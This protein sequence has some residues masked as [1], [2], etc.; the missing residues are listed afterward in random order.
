MGSG[1][2]NLKEILV[3]DEA[4]A[5]IKKMSGNEFI[6]FEN[7]DEAI[8]LFSKKVLE[9]GHMLVEYINDEPAGYI[10]FYCNDHATKTGF[11]TA[12][13]VSGQGLVKGKIIM[14]LAKMAISY[15][16]KAGMTQL[17]VQ[18][19]KDNK[20]ARK[21]YEQLGLEYTGEENENGL[22]MVVSIEKLA[23]AM[24]IRIDD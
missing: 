6:T 14:N 11:V 9:N 10:C 20:H 5:V 16:T 3:L 2:R 18:V 24:R 15:G 13:V 22:Y 19:H 12:I 4:M 1:K 7:N 21:L 23:K 17:R 8:E